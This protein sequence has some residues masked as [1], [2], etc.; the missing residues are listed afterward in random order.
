MISFGFA[1]GISLKFR[2]ILR[3][4]IRNKKLEEYVVKQLLKIEKIK[5]LT[6]FA[7]SMGRF[8]HSILMIIQFV[9]VFSVIFTMLFLL[10]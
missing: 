9:V 7:N 1:L 10:F 4:K 8:A 2:N 3:L 6:E 5:R